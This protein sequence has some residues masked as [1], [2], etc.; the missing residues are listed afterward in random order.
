MRYR[1]LTTVLRWLA[2]VLILRV[3]AALD[4]AHARG[5]VHRDIK[6]SNVLVQPDSPQES[7][8]N[9]VS[10]CFPLFNILSLFPLHKPWLNP[11]LIYPTM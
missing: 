4:H 7:V 8:N 10:V 2:V 9:F 3:L 5:F 11:L 1:I 6:P